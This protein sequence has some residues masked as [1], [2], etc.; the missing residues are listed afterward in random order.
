MGLCSR[1][2][3]HLVSARIMARTSI[4]SMAFFHCGFPLLGG[5]RR[6]HRS[7]SR[8]RLVILL[9]IIPL[10]FS[11]GRRPDGWFPC[12]LPPVA[13]GSSGRP[14]STIHGDAVPSDRRRGFFHIL[15]QD[16]L[17]GHSP[18]DSLLALRTVRP[19][20]H[21]DPKASCSRLWKRSPRRVRRLSGGFLSLPSRQAPLS[22]LFVGGVRGGRK[23][24]CYVPPLRGVH[25][26]PDSPDA[27]H[28][29]IL[30]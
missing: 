21:L 17:R 11:D 6:S 7:I 28:P 24:T 20:A 27:A 10:F 29:L 4:I 8:L 18:F 25:T 14:F 26:T 12:F 1:A 19:R 13:V 3:R 2:G 9:S 30:L 15:F 23:D 22:R 5:Y 16:R